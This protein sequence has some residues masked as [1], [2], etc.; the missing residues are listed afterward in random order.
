[1]SANFA[2]M[3]PNFYIGE[4]DIDEAKGVEK[5]FNVSPE[6]KGRYLKVPENPGWGCNLN[7][8]KL[9]KVFSAKI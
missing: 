8:M 5:I 1:M 3:I 6:I 4:I 2:A 9:E 7:E